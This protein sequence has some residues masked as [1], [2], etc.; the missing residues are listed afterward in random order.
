MERY[1][2]IT[3]VSMAF[4]CFEALAGKIDGLIIVAAADGE[5]LYANDAAASI[6]GYAQKELL[7]MNI[8]GLSMTGREGENSD[9]IKNVMDN[10]GAHQT[11]ALMDR[12]RRVLPFDTRAWS[13]LFNGRA[14]IFVASA[15]HGGEQEDLHKFIKLFELNPVLMAV[16]DVDD[17]TFLDVN[18]SF[19]VKTGYLREEVIGRTAEELHLFA[20]KD[21]QL[22][23][24]H[25]L[26]NSGALRN[27]EIQIK[28]K[29]GDILQGL[30]SAEI[31]EN[32]GKLYLLT[33]MVD[34]TEQVSLRNILED[35][36][37]RLNNIIESSGLG[38]WEWDIK[39]GEVVVNSRWA[40]MVGYSLEELSPVSIDTWKRL[41]HPEDLAYSDGLLDRHFRKETPY[42][43]TEIRMRHKRGDWIWVQDRGRVIEWD[44]DGR[45]LKMFG[46]HSDIT[47][48]KR[49]EEKIRELSIRDFLTNIY[50]RRYVFERLETILAEF[51]RE[52]ISFTVSI[53]DIDHFKKINDTYGHLAGDFVL[54][55]FAQIINRNIRPYD[56][57]GRYGGEEF[58]VVSM[59][60]DR[61]QTRLKMERILHIVRRKTFVYESVE[62][63]MT[64]S[65]GVAESLEYGAEDISVERVLD[66]ADS[67]LYKAKAAGRNRIFISD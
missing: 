56:L 55:E 48:K 29:N 5:I 15:R 47:E 16:N 21:E 38:T 61:E 54:R 64:F 12:D 25:A 6:L 46:T 4:R 43:D 58:I 57:L 40:E 7:G 31:I 59:H 62:I 65:C 24:A 11:L 51:R 2:P 37:D 32:H 3:D 34:I 14:C 35:K 23:L 44:A 1:R 39:T 50:N 8:Q 18:S 67:R 36:K 19:L 49:L 63:K 13:G 33:V 22:H 20:L 66:R 53:I 10:K 17:R 9:S 27:A 42:H 45:P 28:C 41:V 60:V 30:F 26:R 52:R